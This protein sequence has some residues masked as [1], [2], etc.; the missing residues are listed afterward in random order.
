MKPKNSAKKNDIVEISITDI[1]NLGCGV[2]RVNGVVTF[3]AGACTGDE[4]VIRIIKVS[5]D[6]NVGKIEKIKKASLYRTDPD[7]I[8]AKRCGGCVYRHITY[9]HELELKR[10]RVTAAMK[11]AGLSLTVRQV[12]HTG[13]LDGYRNKAQYP[14]GSVSLGKG[15][16]ITKRIAIG[17]YAEKS[18]EIIPCVC[19]DGSCRL[20]PQIFG[21]IADFLRLWMEENKLTAYDELTGKGVMRHLYL[22]RSESTGKVM[23]CFVVTD[24]NEKLTALTRAICDRFPDV[25]S[26]WGNVN[27]K[28]TNVVLGREWHLLY[29]K[30]KLSDILCGRTFEISPQS[31]WQVNRKA[32]EMLYNKAAELAD[33][34]PGERVL[35]LFCGIG[36][37][38]ISV[39]TPDVKLYGIEIVP[40]A[41]EN[42][43][44]NAEINGYS[45]AEFV[46]AD[47]ADPDDFDAHLTRIAKGGLDVVILDP[48]RKGCSPELIK[49][50]C[51]LAPK[52]IVYISCNPDT[53]A[54]DIALFGE[55]YKCEEVT[56]VDMFPR[57]GHCETVCLLSKLNAKQHIEINLDM[58]ELDLTDAE[59]KATYQEI[60]DY[61]L[62]HSGL[63][64]S[65]LYI[66]QVKQQCGIIERENYNKPK[67]EDAKQPQCPPD[68]EKAIKEALRHFGMI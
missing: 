23:V 20:Q 59:K 46:C 65:S 67:S 54:R 64:V 5:S 2:G 53:L 50:L 15:N 32:A 39:T 7:C 35:D 31:F 51:E 11:K 37:V 29:G 4:L 36:T 41:V 60:K 9:E 40:E 62:E 14:I 12:M 3:V 38:G 6:Y 42:A 61:V 19:E 43:K 49:R 57:T 55:R 18:H 27:S 22:R 63:K 48:P 45:N 8:A 34:K 56:P 25:A 33:I 21:E 68:K 17:F 30:E 44:R 52:R 58:D 13:E 10:N 26:V 24:N 1:N 47:A 66:A 28:N 16:N